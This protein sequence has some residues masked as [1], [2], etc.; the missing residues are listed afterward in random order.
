[1]P[2]RIKIMHVLH[3]VGGVD[4]YL[5][6]LLKYVDMEKFEFI[7]VHGTN[8]TEIPYLD[9]SGGVIKEYKLSVQRE[10]NPVLDF[11]SIRE[12]RK[13]L[14]QEKPDL[15]HAHSA[16]GGIIARS[17]AIL[18]KISVLYTPHAFSYLSAETDIKKKLF[19]GI[20][21]IYKNSG[22]FILATSPSEANR[23]IDEIGYKPEKVLVFNN[24]V[25]PVCS[26]EFNNQTTRFE[27]PEDY[28]CSIGRPSYQ[29]NIETMVEVFKRVKEQLPGLSFVLMG[30]GFH[31]PNEKEVKQLIKK[32]NLQDDFIMLPWVSREEIFPIIKKSKFY[33]STSRYEG[34]PYSIIES[35]AL[36][37]ACVVSDCDGN[38]DLIKND[39]NGKIYQLEKLIDKMPTGIIQL[40][41]N[42]ELRNKF[43]QNAYILFEQNYNIE[44]TIRLLEEIYEEASSKS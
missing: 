4:V 38:R 7:I 24:S 29:K 41:Q 9:K 43:E 33:V 18:K 10:I 23:A 1:M 27:L 2:K 34:L 35:L 16:K 31:A 36:G 3:A 13:I 32:Y 6:L 15:I 40:L 25:E 28:I 37:K 17:A 20:E 19:K 12:L 21:K 30:V 22:N 5:R 44:K 26:N 14:D 42:S 39:F 11:R 8:D